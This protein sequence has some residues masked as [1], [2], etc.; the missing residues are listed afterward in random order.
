MLLVLKP[1][2]ALGAQGKGEVYGRPFWQMDK[3]NNNV[4]TAG[5][6]QL[7]VPFVKFT[8]IMMAR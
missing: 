6:I 1:L 4:G 7:I 3:Q 2:V 5:F 8:D